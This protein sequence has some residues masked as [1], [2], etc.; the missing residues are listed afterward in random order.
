V[1]SL[2]LA[3]SIVTAST[4][5]RVTVLLPRD[6]AARIRRVAPE[7]TVEQFVRAATE[8]ELTGLEGTLHVG[9]HEVQ[10]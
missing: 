9:A 4:P 7:Y 3:A 8:A 10:P 1:K 6:F 2:L 5:I